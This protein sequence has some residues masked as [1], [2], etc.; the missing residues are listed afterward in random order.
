MTSRTALAA[1]RALLPLFLALLV[2]SFAQAQTPEDA[3]VVRSA[4]GHNELTLRGLVQADGRLFLN[5][6]T[7]Q[8]VDTFLIRKARIVLQGKLADDFTFFVMPDFGE[9]KTVLQDAW[10]T[11][12]LHEALR[13]TAGRQKVPFGLERLQAD[14]ATTF[15]ERAHPTQLAP[16]RDIGVTISGEV[17]EKRLGY[18]LGAYN[19]GIDNSITDVDVNDSKELAGRLYVKPFAQAEAPWL[20][21]L[22]IGGAATYGDQFGT[23]SATN[24]PSW[25][26]PGQNTIYAFRSGEKKTTTDAAGKSVTTA[27]PNPVTRGTRTRWTVHGYW[28]A[29]PIGL[30][31]EYVANT[32][33]VARG[34][35][36]GD[37]KASAWQGA[38]S[39][40]LG[41]RPSFEGVQIDAPFAAG[42]PGW[43]AF[44]VAARV[45][46]IAA[47]GASYATWAD[48]AKSVRTATSYTGGV[49]WHLSRHYRLYADY[50]HTVFQGGAA[51]NT[52]RTTEQALLGRVQLA[53]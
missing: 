10:V 14:Q 35:A 50:E 49:R 3:F 13:V 24:T 48:P 5:D 8:L 23:D 42:A 37:W 25:K 31:G 29:G 43:G 20:R 27:L 12:Q 45:S 28:A 2:P 17:L 51:G 36:T 33:A 4:N 44:E 41:G 30:L 18:A 6:S 34:S 26:S 9:G 46:G 19:G 22:L 32:E 40:V 38:A 39:Y 53:F 7:K 21:S 1:A 16:N 15:I 52:N 11:W 47:D